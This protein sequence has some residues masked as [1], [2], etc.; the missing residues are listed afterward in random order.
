MILGIDIGGTSAKFGIVNEEGQ[1][2]DTKRFKTVTWVSE[3]GFISNLYKEI[4]E[5]LKAYPN[6]K[7]VGMGW[8]GLLSL[9]RRSVVFLPNIPSVAHV[10]VVGELEALYPG[11]SFKIENDAKCAAMG[12]YRFGTVKDLDNFILITLGTGVGSGAIINGQLF[13]GARGNG[14]EVGHILTHTGKTLEQQV[15]IKNLVA[16]AKHLLADDVKYTSTL[17]NADEIDPKSIQ[18]H[19][20]KG[21]AIAL[22]VYKNAGRLLGETLVGI[23]RTLDLTTVLI[24]GGISPA[25]HLIKPEMEA[26]LKAHLPSYYTNDIKIM[27]ASLS[28]NAGL[29]GAAALLK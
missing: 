10:N 19:A 26:F 7:K 12:E 2:S 14:T 17:N 18:E 16:Y 22:E 24:G 5:Y 9:D 29:L 20:E 4:G 23:I 3:G 15:G 27:Q 13:I 8:P 25:I 21:D 28:N 11:V 1:V 6:L